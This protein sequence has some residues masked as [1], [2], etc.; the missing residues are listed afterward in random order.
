MDRLVCGDVGFGKTEIAMR[1]AFKAVLDGYQVALLA[2]TTIL[3]AQHYATF[4]V[5]MAEHP[6][7][8]A[9]LSR[10]LNTKAQKDVLKNIRNGSVNIVIGTHRILSRDV[11]FKNLGLLIIDEEQRFG[12]R[13]KE[14]LKGYRYSVD[15]LSMTATPIPRTMHMS[16]VG[17]RD[18]SIVNTPPRNRLP[19]ETYVMAYHEDIIKNALENELD[20]GGQVYVVDNRIRN[21]AE[22]QNTI[23][24]AVPRARVV[25]AHGQMDEKKLEAVMKEFVAGTYDVLL[26]TAIIESGLD[27]PNVNTIIVSRAET[28]GLSQLYQLRGRVGRSTEQA[29]AYFLIPSLKQIKENSLKRL[30][31][32]EQ[33]TDLGS[34]FQIAMRD[35]EI[36]GAGNIIGTDQHGTIAMVG[37]E[38][39]CQLLKE[40][41]DRIKGDTPEEKKKEVKID[42]PVDAYL[43][44]EYI[45][46]SATRITLYQECSAYNDLDEIATL[47]RNIIDR[48]GPLPTPV[49]SLLT[50]MELKILGQ[51]T[52]ISHITLGKDDSLSFSFYHQ[53]DRLAHILKNIIAKAGRRFEVVYGTPVV[54]KTSLTSKTAINKILETK[55]ILQTQIAGSSGRTLSRFRCQSVDDS[56]SL[57][58]LSPAG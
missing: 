58:S 9:V 54:L 38:L 39:Y 25:V 18:L 16:L 29:Y 4:S 51:N 53:E 37:F 27:I 13:H 6:I 36:R 56:P 43:P 14:R 40:E 1:A 46:D 2:P 20:R 34:G 24:L 33:Y 22:L 11:E 21:L 32:L 19:I 44:A 28:L 42:I 7:T 26:S 8:I 48:F 57:S 49:Q 12:V 23:E 47:K 41:I 10:F 50:I 30:R 17:I 5:R 55:E 35:L 31:A 15:V 3:A 52:G 45:A